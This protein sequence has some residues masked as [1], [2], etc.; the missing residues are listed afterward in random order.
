MIFPEIKTDP[1]TQGM[2]LSIPEP[3]MQD[4]FNALE[5]KFEGAFSPEEKKLLNG[6]VLVTYN[7]CSRE[8][9]RASLDSLLM[10]TKR[11]ID[12]LNAPDQ[13]RNFKDLLEKL[14]RAKA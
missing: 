3:T 8:G 12:T 4:I 5:S 1:R 13:I 7:Q 2:L 9:K 11:T 10:S 6:L 14:E